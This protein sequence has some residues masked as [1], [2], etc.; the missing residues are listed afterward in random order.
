MLAKI[1]CFFSGHLWRLKGP[2][3]CEFYECARCGH[4]APYYF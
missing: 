1:V 3:Q 2:D 4:T